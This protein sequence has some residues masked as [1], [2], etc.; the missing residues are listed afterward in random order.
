MTHKSAGQL[1]LFSIFQPF[2]QT[3]FATCHSPVHACIC[4]MLP[5]A[6]PLAVFADSCQQDSMGMHRQKGFHAVLV[7]TEETE[8]NEQSVRK[9]DTVKEKNAGIE[10][11]KI[12]TRATRM[13]GLDIWVKGQKVCLFL[14]INPAESS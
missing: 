10:N 6:Y 4:S 2:L 11:V 12:C 1:L 3:L 8:L 9:S 5:N 14:N 13:L 7:T